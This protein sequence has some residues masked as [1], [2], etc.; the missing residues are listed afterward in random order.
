MEMKNLSRAIGGLV[1]ALALTL[2]AH[3]ATATL[4]ALFGGASI[5]AGDKLF[6]QWSLEFWDSSSITRSLNPAN[7]IVTSLDDGGDDPGPGLRFDVLNGELSIR[8]TDDP[9]GIFAYVDLTFGFR[10][11]PAQGKAIKDVS[12]GGYGA[13]YSW[14]PQATGTG[15]LDAG[16]FIQEYVDSQGVIDPTKDT[17]DLAE[18]SVEFSYEE[19][20]GQTSVLSD[21]ADFDPQGSV[22]ITKNILVWA[23]ATTDGASV[24]SFNQRFSQQ[25]VPEPGSLAL[26]TLALA[27]LGAVA[28][29]RR[30]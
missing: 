4:E 25:P 20:L 3:A 7:V 10:V 16:S 18:L 12:M 13:S 27:G 9:D 11:T 30:G 5:T 21:S 29:R 17:A 6:D 15:P 1:A 2:P 24:S 14:N 22:W 26:V 28:R 19:N 23:T 8:G